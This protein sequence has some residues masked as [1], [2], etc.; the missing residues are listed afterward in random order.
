MKAIKN[1]FVQVSMAVY[2]HPL[3][4]K[5]HIHTAFT[6]SN[7]WPLKNVCCLNIIRPCAFFQFSN[8]FLIIV[9]TCEMEHKVRIIMW[10]M[11]FRIWKKYQSI[12]TLSSFC[13]IPMTEV[14]QAGRKKGKEMKWITPNRCATSFL[15]EK[16]EHISSFSLPI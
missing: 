13:I 10:R 6:E 5:F 2:S 9:P 16:H 7:H 12:T 3:S 4:S 15:L 8:E 1:A 11:K 14:R